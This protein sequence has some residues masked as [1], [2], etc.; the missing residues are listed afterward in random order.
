MEVE[1]VATEAAGIAAVV[2]TAAVV[3]VII[4]EAAGM[5]VA[6]IEAATTAVIMG[7]VL[8]TIIIRVSGMEAF[9]IIRLRII[10]RTRHIKHLVVER[11]P[12]AHRAQ[13]NG[14]FF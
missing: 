1:A 7:V 4:T 3:V 2:I 6:I 5:A 9:A 8:T 13:S 14:L 11:S 12:A 10:I